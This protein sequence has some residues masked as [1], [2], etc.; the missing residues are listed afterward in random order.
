MKVQKW[1]RKLFGFEAAFNEMKREFSELI[2]DRTTVHAD[3]HWKQK[4]MIIAIGQYKKRDYVRCFDVE[5]QDGFERLLDQLHHMEKNAH[6]GR[7]D[8]PHG[9]PFK[10]I[11]PRDRF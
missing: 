1:L 6:V 2:G 9:W 3:I 8:M 5:T 4:S 11:Y 7:F 10:A